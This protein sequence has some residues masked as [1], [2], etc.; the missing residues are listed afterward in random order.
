M[1]DMK[2]EF[3]ISPD[4]NIMHFYPQRGFKLSQNCECFDHKT[5]RKSPLAEKIFDLGNIKSVVLT[6]DCVSIVKNEVISWQVLK[7]QIMAE[8]M[9]FVVSGAEPVIEKNVKSKEEI[10]ANVNALMEARIRPAIRK[11][12]GDI[13]LRLFEDGVVYVELKGKCVGC[14]YASRT[15]KDGV[16]K[17]LKTYIP[18]V[19]AVEKYEA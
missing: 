1:F 16:E 9:D 10:L 19:K 4:D 14:P 3:E 2:I 11:D 5:L 13:V 17:L 15:L 8:I 18:G 12:G 6:K 7:P